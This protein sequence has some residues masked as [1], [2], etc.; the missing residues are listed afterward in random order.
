[1]LDSQKQLLRASSIVNAVESTTTISLQS[2]DESKSSSTSTAK[3]RTGFVAFTQPAKGGSTTVSYNLSQLIPGFT[4]SLRV[5]GTSTPEEATIPLQVDGAGNAV[6]SADSTFIQL[7][8][9]PTSLVGKS[10]L[11]LQRANNENSS[12]T[13]TEVVARGIIVAGAL[14][15]ADPVQAKEDTTEAKPNKKSKSGCCCKCCYSITSIG[16]LLFLAYVGYAAKIFAAI[17]MPGGFGGFTY[18]QDER[19][20]ALR[21]VYEPYIHEG[22]TFSFD[23]YLS[24]ASSMNAGA[25]NVS[26]YW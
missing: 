12:S 25:L 26:R 15:V 16:V 17:A 20:G 9:E 2:S 10:V 21:N 3:P 11:I 13:A 5:E 14:P 1:M 6:G 4:Y 8:P 19:T 24:T 23:G 18:D 22:M 7:A